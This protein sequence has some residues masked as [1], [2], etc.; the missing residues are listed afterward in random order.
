MITI[1]ANNA[2]IPKIETKILPL[3]PPPHPLVVGSGSGVGVGSGSGV[4][5]GCG[6]G[7]GSTVSVFLVSNAP[8]AAN[9]FSLYCAAF[10]SLT[11]LFLISSFVLEIT[12]NKA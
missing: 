2:K 7:V 12:F 8:T 6:S 5:V 9:K 11:L 1:A 4:G 10:S 3:H